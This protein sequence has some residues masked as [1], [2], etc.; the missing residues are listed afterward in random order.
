MQSRSHLRI[1]VIAVCLAIAGCTNAPSPA[2]QTSGIQPNPDTFDMDRARN[3]MDATLFDNPARISPVWSETGDRF[4]YLYGDDV[5][6]RN[7]SNGELILEITGE[8][9]ANEVSAPAGELSIEIE[10]GAVDLTLQASGQVWTRTFSKDAVPQP[11]G[12]DVTPRTVRKMFPMNGYDRRENPSPNGAW[13]ASLDGPNLAVRKPGEKTVRALTDESDAHVSWFHGNDIWEDSGNIWNPQ[14]THFIARRHDARSTPGLLSLDYLGKSET[15]TD[16]RYW[17]RAGDPLPITTLYAVDPV[18]GALT[19]LGAPSGPDAFLFFIEW[20][21][22][23]QSVLAIRYARDLSEQT[24]VSINAA[25]GEERVLLQRKEASG[26][27][28]WPSGPRTIRHLNDGRYLLRTDESGFFNYQ[29]LSSE[30][31]L[32]YLLTS[33]HLDVGDII[34][35]DEERGWLYYLAPVSKARPYD[36]IPHRVPLAGGSPEPLADMP[37]TYSAWLSPMGDRLIWRHSHSTRA[38]RT[39]LVAADGELLSVI[40]ETETPSALLGAPLP[41]EATF[42]SFDGTQVHATILKPAGFDPGISYPVIHRV[43][44]GLQSRVQRPGFWPEGLGWPGSEYYTMLNY[45]AAQGFVVVLMDPPGTPG[46]GRA[47]N[48]AQWGVW[49]GNTADHYAAGLRALAADRPWMDL[50][51]VGVEGNSW[52][53]YVALHTAL[54]HPDLYRAAAI[55]VPEIDLLDHVHWIEWQLGSPDKNP[56][57][58]ETGALQK[59]IA[60]LASDLLIVAGTSDANAPVSNTMK[61]L[62]ALAETGTP[63]DLVLFPG[64]NHPHQGRGDRYAYAAER[65]R[66][67]FEDSLAETGTNP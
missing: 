24:I 5:R 32:L 55:S 7:A 19:Q 17:A 27:V 42:E 26:W 57:A 38:S 41:E 62:D 45:L 58:Y 20:S 50:G 8:S 43:Y 29:I 48:L 31:D 9:L 40:E 2:P 10:P 59:R 66:A 22:D 4:A 34:A 12:S 11:K 25:S 18:S 46:R 30:G 14:G 36:Q 37:G 3:Q 53:G 16:F 35:L 60:D 13:L 54:E 28:K 33:A 65:I 21:P 64:T 23:G 56:A 15:L 67:F 47:Y 6:V 52:G 49:P 63:Y 51:R 1:P 61:L 39:E 44:G